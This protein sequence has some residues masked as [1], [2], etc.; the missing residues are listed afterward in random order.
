M[1]P[2]YLV[3]MQ[4]VLQAA[5]PSGASDDEY[6]A[7]IQVLHPHFSLRNL[8]LVVGA[9]FEKDYMEVYFRDIAPA[10][11]RNIS[12]DIISEVRSKLVSC[13]FEECIESD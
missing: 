11:Q 1:I 8:D 12:E 13:G 2:D 5:F 3:P 10:M 6:A 7:A 9:A 4:K